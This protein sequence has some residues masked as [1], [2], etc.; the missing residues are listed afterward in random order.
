MPYAEMF[1]D[2]IYVT[3]EL[4]DKE[5]IK[6][7]PGTRW[8]K[9]EHMW[10]CPLS[11]ASCVALR[12][13]FG[14]EL[15]VGDALNEWAAAVR[16]YWIDKVTPLKTAL[17]EASLMDSEPKLFPF[18]RVGVHFL[19]TA[20]RALLADDMGSGKTIML[21]R[22]IARLQEAHGNA[23]PVLIVCPNS[24]KYTWKKEIEKWYPDTAVGVIDGSKA[25][26][27]RVIEAKDFDEGEGYDFYIINWEALRLHTRIAGYGSIALTDKEKTPGNLNAIEFK[28]VIA[29][30]AHR[31]KDPKSK[32]TRALK[33]IS[34]DAVYRFAATGTPIESSPDQYW[35]LM[36]YI[37]PAD[38]P[39]KTSFIDRYCQQTYNPF[40][41][42]DIVGLNPAT[43]QEFYAITEPRKLRRPKD[44]ILPQLP[45]KVESVRFLPMVGKQKKAYDDM[46]KHM[47]AELKGGEV[48]AALN[49]LQQFTRL[50]QLASSY[51]EMG[52]DDKVLMADPSNKLDAFMELLDEAEGEQV[53]AFAESRQL[54]ELLAERMRDKDIPHG[55]ITGSQDAA[56]RQT[57]MDQFQAGNLRAVLCTSAG[58]EG[59]TLTSARILVFLQRFWS[60]IKNK[61]AADRVHRIG[62]ERGVDIITFASQGTVDEYREQQL[63]EKEVALQEIL[64]DDQIRLDMLGWGKRKR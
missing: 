10:H 23:L 6:Q 61:Q 58:A 51:A 41:G 37:S 21:I 22:T 30:E 49:P 57:V 40:G 54:I 28:A 60:S 38:F 34:K 35:S 7:V 53:V 50:S 15:E 31:A 63:D 47:L 11:W 17:E 9:D 20:G 2:R 5:L 56:T 64:Q 32:Q 33:W 24:M 45:P 36:N 16:Y 43:L 42:M 29:D 12:G 55:L 25:V 18:Q 52:E 62:Q 8:D 14:E 46:A 13:V 48:I 3:T 39:R 59:I 44:V 19:E 4:R 1:D 26:R 27:D